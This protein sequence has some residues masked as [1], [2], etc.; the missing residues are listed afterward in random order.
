MGL[1]G[2][3]TPE[4]SLHRSYWSTASSL[5]EGEPPD[6]PGPEPEQDPAGQFGLDVPLGATGTLPTLRDS[7]YPRT[8]TPDNT[9]SPT[10]RVTRAYADGASFSRGATS[11]S[12]RTAFKWYRAPTLDERHQS[13][14]WVSLGRSSTS[15]SPVAPGKWLAAAP[16]GK[17][18]NRGSGWFT[19]WG[20]LLFICAAC[21]LLAAA[22]GLIA[23]ININHPTD[24]SNASVAS[25]PD[26]RQSTL[27]Y[28]T[29]DLNTTSL[30]LPSTS[31]LSLSRS[32]TVDTSTKTT[33]SSSTRAAS[34]QGT[35]S[36]QASSSQGKSP[37]TPSRILPVPT[38]HHITVTSRLL[39]T[40]S[41]P[42]APSKTV[43][44]P[45]PPPPTT[46]P[47]PTSSEPVTVVVITQTSTVIIT[48]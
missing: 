10:V 1:P 15:S 2:H 45:P 17:R 12:L 19:R 35:S 31:T 3:K 27:A 6:A 5:D 28:P 25:S 13:A 20:H 21:A 36:I 14:A 23:G 11:P 40:G 29:D 8:V 32:T 4:S 37:R 38:A 22:V 9:E 24:R 46:R 43:P 30:L 18:K 33:S 44:P 47:P 34:A 16:V 42:I 39:I 7:D 48:A 41:N 26:S